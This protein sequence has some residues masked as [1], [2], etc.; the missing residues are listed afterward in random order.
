[1]VLKGQ[2]QKTETGFF[3]DY[4]TSRLQLQRFSNQNYSVKVSDQIIT[5]VSV[6]HPDP[7]NLRELEFCYHLPV[8]RNWHRPMNAKASPCP[9]YHGIPRVFG[10]SFA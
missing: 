6:L 3:V 8:P 1:M 4:S 9:T 5:S 2:L 10:M 7:I